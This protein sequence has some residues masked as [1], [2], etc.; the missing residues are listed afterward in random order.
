M[1]GSKPQRQNQ[2]VRRLMSKIKRFEKAG[3][4]TT[5]LQRELD[6]CTGDAK[7]PDFKTGRDADPRLK[8]KYTS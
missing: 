5:K 3:K 1:K 2:H 6:Y 7:R 8:K 4:N